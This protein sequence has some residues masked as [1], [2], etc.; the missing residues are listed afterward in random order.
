MERIVL[1]FCRPLKLYMVLYGKGT[2]LFIALSSLGDYARI[3]YFH[4]YERER[5]YI[6]SVQCS[7][8]Y[9][10]LLLHLML[11][12]SYSAYFIN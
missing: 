10:L 2:V 11:I 12:K 1:L 6:V 4:I 3:R 7:V 9:T 8:Q 5:K